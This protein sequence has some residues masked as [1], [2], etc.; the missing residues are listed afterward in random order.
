[1]SELDKIDKGSKNEIHF[2]LKMSAQILLTVSFLVLLGTWFF[3]MNE[4]MLA[5]PL[6]SVLFVPIVLF[7]V[8]AII[9]ILLFSTLGPSTFMA[10]FIIGSVVV[11]PELTKVGASMAMGNVK[12]T[13]HYDE[14]SLNSP[15]Y[16]TGALVEETSADENRTKK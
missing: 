11:G 10:I 12:T 1:M 8:M 16:I 6:K 15:N 5:N 4:S 14:G 9:N 7:C 2:F 3:L 13:E